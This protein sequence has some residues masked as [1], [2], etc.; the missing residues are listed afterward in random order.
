MGDQPNYA[1]LALPIFLAALLTEVL[2]ARRR[3]RLRELF[4]LG[5]A[6]SDIGCGAVFQAAEVLLTVATFAAYGWIYEHARLVTWPEGS[7]WPWVIGLLGVD[8]IY[9]WWHRISHVVNVM[10][11][12]HGVHHQSEDYNLAVALRQ[13][14]LEPVTW[15]MLAWTLAILGVPT[16]VMVISFGLNLFY[17]FWIHTELVDKL[18]RPLEA[19]LNTPSHHRVHHGVDTEY[20]DRNYGGVLILWDKLFGTFQPEKQRPHYGTTVPLRSYNPLWG[21]V[22]HLV[23]CWHLGRAASRWSDKVW[24][25]FAHPAWLPQGVTDPET[26]PDRAAYDKYRP[27]LSRRLATYVVLNLLLVVSLAGPFVF[28]GHSLSGLQIAAAAVSLILGHVALNALIE[29]KPWAGV[30]DGLR[31]VAVAAT[32][33]W[34]ASTFAGPTVGIAT[35]SVL[36]L[37]P[38]VTRLALRPRAVTATA[39]AR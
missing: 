6:I 9:Y 19:V 5:T 25:W 37:L 1:A 30:V 23:R 14:L 33:G 2:V 27:K 35:A 8:F 4:S 17:Q 3:G 10:W 28:V 39:T 16:L 34:L 15:V 12:V 22:Q 26:K 21:N 18:P 29:D 13:P 38:L 31:I 11:A 20:L 36:V 7:P 32:A 24:V